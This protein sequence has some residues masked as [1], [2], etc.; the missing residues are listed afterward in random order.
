MYVDLS[1]SVNE[2]TVVFPGDAKPK[3]QQAGSMGKDGFVDHIIHIN[4]HLGTHVDFPAHM[5]EGGGGLLDYSLE[6]FVQPAVCLNA[7]D[8]DVL[9]PSILEGVEVARGSAILFYTGSSERSEDESYAEQYPKFSQE[10]ADKLVELKVSMVGVDMIS[11]DHDVPFPIHKTLLSAD[12]LLIENLVN[13]KAIVNKKVKLFAMPIKF[14]LD[15]APAR[16]FAEI[17]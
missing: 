14:Q 11:Y 4:N 15:A 10:L 6:R 5:V 12:I 16:V 1:M 7:T 13:L 9:M 3:F 2:K 8:C 17:E